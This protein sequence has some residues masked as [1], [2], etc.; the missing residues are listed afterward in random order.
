M[1]I[2]RLFSLAPKTDSR[3]MIARTIAAKSDEQYEAK[4]QSLEVRLQA[5][6]DELDLYL[7]HQNLSNAPNYDHRNH[8]TDD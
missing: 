5:L 1:S 4:I 8:P 2:Y 3:R 7:I 6:S